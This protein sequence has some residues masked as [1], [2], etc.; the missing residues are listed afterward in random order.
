M[1]N[2]SLNTSG[3]YDLLLNEFELLFCW[4]WLRWLFRI[5]AAAT[6]RVKI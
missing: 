1:S 6:G 2:T 5:T 3:E 4:S